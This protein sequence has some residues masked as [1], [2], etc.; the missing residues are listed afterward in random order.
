MSI[1]RIA[2]KMRECLQ[3]GI[4]VILRRDSDIDIWRAATTLML[5]CY[6]ERAPVQN[7]TRVLAP[8]RPPRVIARRMR[9]RMPRTA[10]LSLRDN[11]VCY[12]HSIPPCKSEDAVKRV[13][14]LHPT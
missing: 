12:V 14:N 1:T 13:N 4:G 11:R 9:A 5:K 6:A 10:L 7:A 2:L 3:M 8:G